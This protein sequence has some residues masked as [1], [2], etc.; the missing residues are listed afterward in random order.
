MSLL[1]PSICMEA[2]AYEQRIERNKWEG[3]TWLTETKTQ[4]NTSIKNTEDMSID[5]LVNI[6]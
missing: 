4:Y 3:V 1:F 6:S 2:L 5:Q